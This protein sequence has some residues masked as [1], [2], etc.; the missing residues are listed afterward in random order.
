MSRRSARFFR[1]RRRHAD[2]RV[3][4]VRQPRRLEDENR[5]LKQ[6]G[7]DLTLNKALVREAPLGRRY[8]CPSR[9]LL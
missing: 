5:R 3:R 8:A 9:D 4:E 6:L 1:W 7:A 2:L